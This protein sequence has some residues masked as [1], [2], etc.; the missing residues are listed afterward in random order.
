VGVVRIV[1]AVSPT[2]VRAVFRTV[3]FAEAVSWAGL[4]V[5]M[6]LKWIVQD[7]PHA[8][9]EGGVPIMGPIHGVL[10][11][12]YVAMC[13][14]ARRTFRW[15]TRTT[16][17]ALAASIPPFLTAVFEVAADRRGMLAVDHAGAV[18]RL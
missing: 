7:D 11:I 17:V 18:R 1:K 15:S 10:F 5:A 12:G 3:A 9:L 16:I 14:V 8:G 2:R 4:L 13:F 6:V